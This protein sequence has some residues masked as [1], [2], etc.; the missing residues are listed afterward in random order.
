[1]KDAILDVGMKLRFLVGSTFM[2]SETSVPV[3]VFLIS[4]PEAKNV[5][6]DETGGYMPKIDIDIP[7]NQRIMKL[8]PDSN[9]YLAN[10]N[11]IKM[12]QKRTK[13]KSS[14][15]VKRTTN[16]KVVPVPQ[17]KYYFYFRFKFSSPILDIFEQPVS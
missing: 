11:V 13:K 15:K 4:R 16:E 12:P 1:M 17:R 8:D 5:Y 6:N 9:T 2:S 14:Q 10:F 3:E 7:E